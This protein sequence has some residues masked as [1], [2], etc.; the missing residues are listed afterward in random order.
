MCT[1]EM[2]LNSSLGLKNFHITD[3]TTP[4]RNKAYINNC[5]FCFYI[6]LLK[7]MKVDTFNYLYP[8]SHF[9]GLKYAIF[10]SRFNRFIVH[11]H[12]FKDLPTHSCEAWYCFELNI[13][14]VQVDKLTMQPFLTF[15][16][17]SKIV[18]VKVNPDVIK[19]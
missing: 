18:S 4:C 12:F 7:K 9:T 8:I 16:C 17:T 2:S 10:L 1:C 15:K 11:R 5:P 13:R 3:F 6:I 14:L 19:V